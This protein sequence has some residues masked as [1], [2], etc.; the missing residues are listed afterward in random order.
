MRR[1]KGSNYKHDLSHSTTGAL[2]SSNQCHQMTWTSRS[3][4]GPRICKF[5]HIESVSEPSEKNGFLHNKSV[6]TDNIYTH[7]R[8]LK[9]DFLLAQHIIVL[10][11]VA[12]RQHSGIVRKSFEVLH[13]C[14]WNSH[15]NELLCLLWQRRL[16]FVLKVTICRARS[17][18]ASTRLECSKSLLDIT[19]TETDEASRK[20]VK[21]KRRNSKVVREPTTNAR[22]RQP[23][24]KRKDIICG[25]CWRLNI[26]NG[27]TLL[28]F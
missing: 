6:K 15:S 16:P 5:S 7:L 24:T 28:T 18:V 12:G 19:V 13:F 8:S 21:T 1:L 11:F 17:S 4:R 27:W 22:Q 14:T 20:S 3:L 23:H 26:Y 9:S 2:S 25:T 10:S